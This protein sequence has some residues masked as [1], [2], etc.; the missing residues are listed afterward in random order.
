ML[1]QRH[2]RVVPGMGAGHRAWGAV[3]FAA[4]YVPA[5]VLFVPGSLLTLGAGFVFGVVKGTLIVSLGSTAGAAAAFLVGRSVARD[6]VARRIAGRPK[7]AAIGRAVRNRRLQVR[8][9]DAPVAGAAVQPAELR[10]RVDRA[11][12]SGH[13]CSRRGS[14]CCREPSC[15]SISVRPPTASPPCYR[16]RQPRSTGQQVLFA[17]G[18]AATVAAGD[19][20]DAQLRRR[21]LAETVVPPVA[22]LL[23]APELREPPCAAASELVVVEAD[24]ILLVVVLVVLLGPVER[25]RPAAISVTIGF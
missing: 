18:L 20:R 8:P 6:W 12:R 9:A 14:G 11:C 10:V 4:A 3:L 13:T 19:R 25:S 22:S 21:A 24:R 5:A 2:P 16:A 1:W 7:L 15:T 23:A 17:L